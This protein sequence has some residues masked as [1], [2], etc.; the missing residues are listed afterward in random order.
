MYISVMFGGVRV[1]L[2]RYNVCVLMLGSCV[3][4][5]ALGGF[6]G[7]VVVADSGGEPWLLG[8]N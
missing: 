4:V 8:Q 3:T 2:K 6:S 1:I 5:L 7:S